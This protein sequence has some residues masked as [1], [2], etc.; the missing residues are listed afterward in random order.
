[1]DGKK[2]ITELGGERY[3]LDETSNTRLVDADHSDGY[4]FSEYASTKTE[5][6]ATETIETSK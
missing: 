1:M 4:K 5:V 3:L 6:S 2:V